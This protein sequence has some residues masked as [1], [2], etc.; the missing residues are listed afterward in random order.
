MSF[1]LK[2]INGDLVVNN[3]DLA[4]IEGGNKLVQD[5]LKLISTQLG[6]N[7]FF[8]AYGCL[9][10]SVL[11]GTAYDEGFVQDI[12][13]QQLESALERLQDS[14]LEQ[15]KNNQ[16]VTADEQIATFKNVRVVRYAN[17][18][19]AFSVSLTVI[20]KAFQSIPVSFVISPT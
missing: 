19:R 4:I 16:I 6:S 18:L 7:P 10:T 1:D 9:I 8:P 14:Q 11:I 12:A 17:D 13:T 20:S 5:V 2:L 3:G 15:L